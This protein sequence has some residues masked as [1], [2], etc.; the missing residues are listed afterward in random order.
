VLLIG[1]FYSLSPYFLPIVLKVLFDMGDALGTAR[2]C[3]LGQL[4]CIQHAAIQSG[5]AQT[6]MGCVCAA[7]SVSDAPSTRSRRLEGLRCV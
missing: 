3:C 4:R 2:S 6:H 1:M 7:L 5:V